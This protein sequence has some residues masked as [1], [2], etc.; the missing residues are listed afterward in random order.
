MI[1]EGLR[2]GAIAAL[3]IYSL[4]LTYFVAAIV[5]FMAP[6]YFMHSKLVAAKKDLIEE[7]S[8]AG[9]IA[10]RRAVNKWSDGE[11]KLL[12]FYE[13]VFARILAIPSWPINLEA[14]FKIFT[15]SLLWPLT[16]GVL[17]AYLKSTAKLP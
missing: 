5:T 4:L 15:T 10:Y 17:T 16:V 6:V 14:T 1:I 8:E 9:I 2:I 3:I 7:F 13:K 11:D 12:N